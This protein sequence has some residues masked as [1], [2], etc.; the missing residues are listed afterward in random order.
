VHLP[1]NFQ[2]IQAPWNA[3]EIGHMIEEYERLVPDGE[4]PNWVLGNHD[5]SRI[6]SRVAAGQ[7][8]VAA[9]LLLT[10]RGTPTMYY[11]DEIGMADVAI[12]SDRVQDPW[13]QREPGLG[14]GRDPQRTPMHWDSSPGAGFTTGLPWLPLAPDHTTCNVDSLAREPRSILSLYKKLIELRRAHPAL[15]VGS[16]QLLRLAGN[17]LAYERVQGEERM[18]VL[19]NLGHEPQDVPL[20]QRRG[21]LLLSTHLDRPQGAVAERLELRGDEGVIIDL[22]DEAERLAVEEEAALAMQAAAS[23]ATMPAMQTAWNGRSP[24]VVE[25]MSS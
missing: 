21:V 10:L 7:A 18:L 9:M 24:W 22:E 11:G 19:L 1:F 20:A 25:D 16:K 12:P 4:W 13:E 14:L 23:R 17:V 5:K 15:A 2:L 3:S 8:R 6:A